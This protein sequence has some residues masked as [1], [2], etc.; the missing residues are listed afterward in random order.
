MPNGRAGPWPG[1]PW[2][3]TQRA[4]RALGICRGQAA[5]LAAGRLVKG[6]CTVVPV[7][8][9]PGPTAPSTVYSFCLI[10]L[11]SGCALAVRPGPRPALALFLAASWTCS[12]RPHLGALELEAASQ[13]TAPTS[14]RLESAPPAEGRMLV[15]LPETFQRPPGPLNTEQNSV[16]LSPGLALPLQARSSWPPEDT[17]PCRWTG[18][19]VM[20]P[21]QKK[22]SLKI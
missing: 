18:H 8:T 6:G 1:L 21:G 14:A 15:T 16:C 11:F 10:C 12:L 5:L 9:S 22:G 2:I 7:P 4:G 13:V 20:T 17:L 19:P 3:L